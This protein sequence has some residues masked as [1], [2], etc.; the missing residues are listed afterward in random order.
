MSLLKIAKILSELDNE[1]EVYSFL[2]ELFTEGE[3]SDLSKRW[4]ILELLKKGY[5]QRAISNEL[6][7]SLCKITR[8]AKII[9]NK[10][11]VTT[12]YLDKEIK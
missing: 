9:K 4:C 2:N 8:G 7:V 10:N 1:Q 11:S 6:N 5:T 3:L 12:R